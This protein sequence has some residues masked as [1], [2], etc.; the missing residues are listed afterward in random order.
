MKKAG[1][2]QP[3]LIAMRSFGRV[4]WFACA[5]L[6]ALAAASTAFAQDSGSDAAERSAD[7]ETAG[8][9]I[10][11]TASRVERSGFIAPTPTTVVGAEEFGKTG[12]S[13]IGSLLNRLPQFQGSSTPTTTPLGDGI[14]NGQN[15]L[16]LRGLGAKRTLVLVDG[17]RFVPTNV[18][19][20]LD[21]NLI[22]A[23]LID[24]FEV[25]TGGASASWG[26]DAVA[27]VVNIILKKRFTGVEVS[28]QAGLSSRG[29]NVE[30][31]ASLAF[32]TDFAG[33]RGHFMA[34]G[35]IV[36]ND[37]ILAQSSRPWGRRGYQLIDNPDYTPENGQA[38]QLIAENVKL[39]IATR[40]G[41]FLFGPPGVGMMQFTPDGQA[42]PFETGDY[43]GGPGSIAMIGGDG[44]NPGADIQLLSP[45]KRQVAYARLSYDVADEVT[46]YVEGSYGHSSVR[47]DRSYAPAILGEVLITPENPYLPDTIR[48]AM[49]LY[50]IPALPLFRYSTDFGYTRNKGDKDV[51]RIVGG[52]EGGFGGGWKWKASYGYGVTDADGYL[53]NNLIMSRL[54]EAADVVA[55][56]VDGSP[57]C[58]STLTAP[59]NGCLPINLFG[60]GAPDPAA[61]A[62]VVGTSTLLSRLTQH[63]ASAS[64]AGEPFST[65]AGPVSIATGVEYRKESVR[66]DSD[67]LSQDDAFQV[68]N[69]K[70]LAGSYDVVE[71]FGEAVVPLLSDQ[72]FAKQLDLS[73][74][75]RV[76]DY[77]SSGRVT[78]WKLGLSYEINDNL[79]LR[80][81]RSRDIRAPNLNELFRPSE[82]RYGSV[83]DPETGGSVTTALLTVGNTSL[84]PEK[85]DTT[86]FGVVYQPRWLRGFR[87]SVDYYDIK[88]AGA[89]STLQP[90]DIV[91]RCAA[92]NDAFCDF[93]TRNGA[94]NIQSIT[95]SQ[96]NLGKVRTEG[97][98]V[99]ALYAMPVGEGDLTLRLLST[100]V[101]HLTTDDGVTAID[102]AGDVGADAMGV[103]HWRATGSLSYDR[104]PLSL[105]LAGR[106]VGGG[107]YDHSASIANNDIDGVFYLDG[108]VQFTIKEEGR[109]QIQLTLA[110][111]NLLDKDPPIAPS[112]FFIPIATNAALYDV[113]GRTF[114]AGVR[115]TF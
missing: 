29:D 106:Y 88:L 68:G 114:T 112:A 4:A 95:L 58:R 43:F 54:V 41:L 42:V 27:G 81:T 53:P 78:T 47:N 84:Q 52:L 23:A 65:W 103:P 72:P 102:R 19:G 21:T 39:A 7:A 73:A 82:L 5:S 3:G 6:A 45:F 60:E 86:S 30:K 16:D 64:I 75:I 46:A 94:G 56:P 49:N 76:A 17:K 98:D 62:R 83:L 85:A 8:D 59:G 69:A 79:R 11:V 87:L 57:V 32:G 31:K 22:P 80:G 18:D 13:S 25:V 28:A 91:N 1:I 61:V 34:A 63:A 55:S 111:N 96:I 100:Y 36:R 12:A 67:L 38:R 108:S 9:D 50:G 99:E 77:S 2:Y 24:R 15:R 14:T 115:V 90:Q 33:G 107:K 20:S 66:I 113:I 51:Y 48:D 26:S 44:Y 71:G 37:G 70:P 105:Y 109:R 92:G 97:V 101:A 35:E 89:I 93:V 110:G 74:A 10:V 40:G 104:G